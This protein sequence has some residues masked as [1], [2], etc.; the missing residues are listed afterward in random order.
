MM[1]RMFWVGLLAATLLLTGPATVEISQA[2]PAAQMP[3]GIPSFVWTLTSFPGV[4]EIAEPR[5]SIQF[6]PDG[7][8]AI[9]ADC[10]R[11]AGSWSGGDGALDITVTMQSLALCPEDSLEQPYLDA[12][13]GV[14]GYTL[15][16]TTLV[17]HGAAGDLP[18]SV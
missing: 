2:A 7:T 11:A 13:N 1:K 4:G 17:L 10:N 15:S 9:G 16:G 8:A 5:Y 3:I 6:M 12:L 18:F 14:T